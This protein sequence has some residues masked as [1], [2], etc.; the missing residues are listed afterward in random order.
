VNGQYATYATMVYD[1]KNI[2]MVKN[3][4]GNFIIPREH[5]IGTYDIPMFINYQ[6]RIKVYTDG[7]DI[8]FN[9]MYVADNTLN[10]NKIFD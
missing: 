4:D 8:T 1:K 9:R 6:D 7:T 5:M 3:N 10:R 2:D